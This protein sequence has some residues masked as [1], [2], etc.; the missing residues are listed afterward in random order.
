LTD[1]VAAAIDSKTKPRGSLGD[2]ESLA[3]RL[4]AIQ[5]TL[6]PRLVKPTIA[7]FAADHGLAR[8]P[9]SAYP[10]QVTA[11]MAVNVLH[12]G[13]GIN[14]FARQHRIEVLLVDA[15]VDWPGQPPAGLINHSMGP[16]TASSL[17]GPAM[18]LAV[19]EQCLTAGAA[20]ADENVDPGCTVLGFGEL[21]I[22][23]TS[24]ASL[25]VSALTGLS[26]VDC[27]GPGTGLT[28]AGL[29][30]KL[31][32]LQ[33]VQRRHGRPATAM[34]TLA[35]FGGF[36]IAQMCGAMRQ[37]WELGQVLLI[38]GF[39]ATAALLVIWADQP[40]ILNQAIFCHQSGEPGHAGVLSYLG[41]KPLLSLGMR[42]GEGSGCAV[43]YPILT[44]AVSFLTDMASFEQAGVST[45]EPESPAP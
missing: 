24:A 19:A 28:G 34:A 13:A 21:G 45:G 35:S 38:D 33:Q 20:V 2:L 8:E 29:A 14:V 17:T 39:V 31:D 41:V 9:V 32:L 26:L 7:V 43:A 12:G 3:A 37:A 27:V 6:T 15:G 10:R 18:S 1:Q 25:I 11:Q 30:R 16:G 36:E 4:C 42:L 23:N 40:A 22:G 44:S 5:Q